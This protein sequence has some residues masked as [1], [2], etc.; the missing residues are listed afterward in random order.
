MRKRYLSN[1]EQTSQQSEEHSKN[2]MTFSFNEEGTL[3]RYSS[4]QSNTLVKNK[5]EEAKSKSLADLKMYRG[6]YSP[7]LVRNLFCSSENSTV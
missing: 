6:Q 1:T 7:A 3:E 4:H 5:V 2:Q